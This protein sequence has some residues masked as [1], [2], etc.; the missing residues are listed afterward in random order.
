MLQSCIS[1][2]MVVGVYTQSTAGIQKCQEEVP[3]WGSFFLPIASALAPLDRSWHMASETRLWGR[4]RALRTCSVLLL[5]LWPK[6][7]VMFQVT[8][9]EGAW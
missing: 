4:D 6:G 2:S 7:S 1:Q 9:K 5:R 8:Q 3:V